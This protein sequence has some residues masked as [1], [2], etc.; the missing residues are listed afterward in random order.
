MPITEKIRL[1][2]HL[3]RWRLTWSRRDIDFRPRGHLPDR[4]K[5]AREAAGMIG[6]GATVISCGLGGN[7]RCS[8]FYWAVRDVFEEAGRPR[9]LTWITVGGVGG[10]G[11][12]PGTVEE[13]ALP[14]LVTRYITG[15]YETAKAMLS[16]ADQHEIEL[17]T[18]PQGEMT[19]ALEAQIGGGDSVRSR[20]GIGT[21]L[22][23]RVG[24]GSPVTDAAGENFITVAGDELEFR[25]PK[26]D[27]ALMTA[28]YADARGNIYFHNAAVMTES[29]EA[30]KAARANGGCAMAAV[31]DIIDEDPSRIT[32]PAA[33][34]DVVVV[35]PRNEQ[36]AGIPQ[37][38]YWREFTPGG[39]G[40]DAAAEKRLKYLNNLLRITPYRGPAEDAVARLGATLFARVLRPGCTANVGIG[41]GEEVTRVLCEEGLL[42]GITF[43]TETGVYGGRPAPGVFFGA[44]VNPQRLESSAWM[45]HHYKEHLDAA[46][47]GYLEVDSDG[48][49]NASNR[50]ER[51]YDY[52]GPGGL[53]SITAGARNVFFVGGW[54]SGAKWRIEGDKLRLQQRGRNKFVDHVREITFNGQVA[55]EEGKRVFYVTNVGVFELT[56]EGLMLEEVMPGID[57]ERDIVGGCAARIVLPAGGKVPVAPSPVVTGAGFSLDWEK[58]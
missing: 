6:D 31:G 4:F 18:M 5:S 38:R 29:V 47:L 23:P 40:D 14:G 50:G 11:K 13:V 44:A 30:A 9:N 32:I 1:L 51:F 17:H 33:D 16:L 12:V 28:P 43:T 2:I 3:L 53:P 48:N 54:M 39:D 45:F 41:Y 36:A 24:R 8:I 26:I 34:I 25:L 56:R 19:H 27:V 37:R 15:H 52:I 49:V 35:N 42:D 46:L 21:V 58:D 20:T 55:L 57:I 22:D 10:R 7:A